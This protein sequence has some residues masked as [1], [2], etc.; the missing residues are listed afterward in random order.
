MVGWLFHFGTRTNKKLSMIVF[1]DDSR[2]FRHRAGMKPCLV[3]AIA[4][5][6][7]HQRLARR[8]WSIIGDLFDALLR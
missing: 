1:M 4:A 5:E 6:R 7:L 8:L 2:V 3:Q